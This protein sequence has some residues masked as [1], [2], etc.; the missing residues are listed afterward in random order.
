[1]GTLGERNDYISLDWRVPLSGFAWIENCKGLRLPLMSFMHQ[2]R[3][4]GLAAVEGNGFADWV[5]NVPCRTYGPMDVAGLHREFAG[6]ASD[7]VGVLSFANRFGLLGRETLEFLATRAHV[8]TESVGDVLSFTG[9]SFNAHG[10]VLDLWVYDITKMRTLVAIKDA[11]N[12]GPQAKE[13]CRRLIESVRPLDVPELLRERDQ[14]E[15]EYDE[16]GNE[17]IPS[18]TPSKA[19]PYY[20]SIPV[21]GTSG[22]DMRSTACP[23]CLTWEMSRVIRFKDT[24]KPYTGRV[25]T[26]LLRKWLQWEVNAELR[27]GVFPQIDLGGSR[28]VKMQ[29]TDLLGAIYAHFALEL[30]G[31]VGQLRRCPS[32]GEWFEPLHGRQD[33]CE[34][35]C[36]SRAYRQRRKRKEQV[37]DGD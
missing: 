32:C 2:Y 30:T 4:P 35:R 27:K 1:M 34:G 33:Y 26:D 11:L 24:G 20:R 37:T 10:E 29:P 13:R 5:R 23:Y 7:R 3:G 12:A 22:M 21:R 36:K 17:I 28:R 15:Y 14:P 16:N 8:G 18:S 6:T 19:P 31:Q 9:R 25:D